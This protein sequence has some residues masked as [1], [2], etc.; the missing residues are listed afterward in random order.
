MARDDAHL[1]PAGYAA[2]ERLAGDF[3]A[4]GNAGAGG[5]EWHEDL[6]WLKPPNEFGVWYGQVRSS[7]LARG[8]RTCLQQVFGGIRL[9]ISIP[10]VAAAKPPIAEIISYSLSTRGSFVERCQH[11]FAQLGADPDIGS[12]S[13]LTEQ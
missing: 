5:A 12:S 3:V 11:L 7:A 2:H 6:L 9:V 4:A 1:R 13:D 10:G 8:T